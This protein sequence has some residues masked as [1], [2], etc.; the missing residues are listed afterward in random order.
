MRDVIHHT[1]STNIHSLQM[2]THLYTHYRRGHCRYPHPFVNPLNVS[3]WYQALSTFGY[4]MHVTY[5]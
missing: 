2:H 1:Y 4:Y 5:S 3:H